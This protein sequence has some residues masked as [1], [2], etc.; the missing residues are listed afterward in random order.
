[1]HPHP[2][3]IRLSFSSLAQWT[4]CR[5]AAGEREMEVVDA[6]ANVTGG[7]RGIG[8]GVVDEIHFQLAGQ[9]RIVNAAAVGEGIA[10]A[11]TT[12]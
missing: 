11:S 8:I 12:T 1:M 3:S 9:R 4:S 10:G 2:C 7:E 5:H 6:P